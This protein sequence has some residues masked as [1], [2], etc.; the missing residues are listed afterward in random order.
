MSAAHRKQSL[1]HRLIR[2]QRNLCHFCK[3]R[4]DAPASGKPR[5]ATLEHLV[6]RSIDGMRCEEANTVAACRTCNQA[7]GDLTEAEFLDVLAEFNRDVA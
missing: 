6:P 4:M 3:R 7:K 1:R 5:E 2:T